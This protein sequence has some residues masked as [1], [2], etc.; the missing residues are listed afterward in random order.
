M[1]AKTK[2]PK[3]K[4][5][6]FELNVNCEDK[7]EEKD[8]DDPC[9]FEQVCQMIAAYNGSKKP[10]ES[11]PYSPRKRATE[12][13]IPNERTR[14]AQHKLCRDYGQSLRDFKKEFKELVE[15]KKEANPK[16]YMDDPEIKSKFNTDC[17]HKR[18]KEKGGKAKPSGRRPKGINPDHQHPVGLKGDP[19]GELKWANSDVNQTVGPAMAGHDPKKEPGGIKAH[20]SCKCE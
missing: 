10:K 16:G 4:P 7:K 13:Q 19:F 2:A 15:A 14:A 6:Q 18:W 8:W 1:M 17:E 5:K 20:K 9:D 11:V 3:P 12:E